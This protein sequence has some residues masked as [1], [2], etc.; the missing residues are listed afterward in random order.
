MKFTYTNYKGETEDREVIPVKLEYLK[1]PGFGYEP[2]W[3]LTCL[4]PSRKKDGDPGFRSFRI[5]SAMKPIDDVVEI[6]S[7]KQ[8]ED[9]VDGLKKH[10]VETSP[11]MSSLAA[12]YL[13]MGEFT[14]LERM[15]TREGQLELFRELK[16]VS[17][18]ALRNDTTP[19]QG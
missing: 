16:S 15:K 1:E 8:I 7:L 9:A 14:F 6:G 3:F 11:A 5:G 2:G 13:G 17:A 18:S 4:D 12:R 10:I 19:G